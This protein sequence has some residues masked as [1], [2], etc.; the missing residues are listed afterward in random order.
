MLRCRIVQSHSQISAPRGMQLDQVFA[1]FLRRY[2][3]LVLCVETLVGSSLRFDEA[4]G[5]GRGFGGLARGEDWLRGA[6]TDEDWLFFVVEFVVPLYS[7]AMVRLVILI[8]V[9][10]PTLLPVLLSEWQ[11]TIHIHES[12]IAPVIKR[13]DSRSTILRSTSPCLFLQLTFPAPVRIN[14]TLEEVTVSDVVLS[15]PSSQRIQ[16][17]IEFGHRVLVFFHFTQWFDSIHEVASPFFVVVR[18]SFRVSF[19]LERVQLC[20]M[21]DIEEVTQLGAK[22]LYDPFH[23]KIILV[24]LLSCCEARCSHSQL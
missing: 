7:L 11:D 21:T 24:F 19:H 22:H 12:D 9:R 10:I 3:F 17:S 2:D 20:T 14:L 4:I 18:R 23:I 5:G 1:W 15:H 6:G 16:S 8:L 13:A